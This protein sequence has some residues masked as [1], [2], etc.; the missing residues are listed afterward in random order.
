MMM[1]IKGGVPVETPLLDEYG[2]ASAAYSLRNLSSTTTNV[3]RVRR[4]SDNAEQNFTSNE[5]TDGTLTVFTGVNDGFVTTWYDQSGNSN[6]ATELT[7]INQPKMVDNGVLILNEKNSQPELIANNIIKNMNWGSAFIPKTIITV[8]SV[9]EQEFVSVVSSGGDPSLRFRNRTTNSS[10]TLQFG[11]GASKFLNDQLINIGSVSE[12]NLT[13]YFN[14]SYN[15]TFDRIGNSFMNRGF[16]GKIQELIMY[17]TNEI[18]NRQG[19]STNIN[20]KY[21]I[22]ETGIETAE[23]VYSLRDVYNNNNAVI[24]VRRSSDN[25]EQ[26]FTA[27][28]IT[29][30]TLETFCV[31]QDGFATTWYD[32]SENDNHSTQASATNQ[33]KVVSNGVLI[34]DNEKPA[35]DYN[36]NGNDYF[37][38]NARITNSQNVYIVANAEINTGGNTQFL[39]GDSSNYAYHSAGSGNSI[40][41]SEANSSVKNGQNYINSEL[42]NFL[43]TSRPLQQTLYTLLHNSNNSA[44]SQITRDRN[45]SG[46]SWKGLIQEIIIFNNDQSLSR[47]SIENNINTHYSI[48]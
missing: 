44:V 9:G 22:Y 43:A 35:L 17:P 5:I 3:V 27:T 45:I 25:S 30:G 12:L 21:N 38:L 18:I 46:R 29:D 15:T 36:N 2:G 24:R 1:L 19:I 41:G 31:S 7:A 26:D 16:L 4:S 40:L 13:M 39:L 8:C 14:G 42:K 32:Q 47:S 20:N 6:D 48:Y 10:G 33:P 37:S 34:L 11:Q 23:I 28:E